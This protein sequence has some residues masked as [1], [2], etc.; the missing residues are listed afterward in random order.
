[1]I[2]SDVLSAV[3]LISYG[4]VKRSANHQALGYDII[5][6]LPIGDVGHKSSQFECLL[7]VLRLDSIL[8]NCPMSYLL[9]HSS[10]TSIVIQ[11]TL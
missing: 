4:C 1:M 11:S 3:F 6:R 5:V 7:Q 8:A 10:S 9:L 2:D